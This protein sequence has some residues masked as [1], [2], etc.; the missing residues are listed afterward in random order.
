MIHFVITVNALL[1]FVC[2]RY[3][4]GFV[5]VNLD[6]NISFHLNLKWIE[7]LNGRFIYWRVCC[8]VCTREP[9]RRPR[10]PEFQRSISHRHSNRASMRRSVRVSQRTAD[11]G[12]DTIYEPKMSHAYSDTDLRYEQLLSQPKNPLNH[13]F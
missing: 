9:K 1:P 2:R 8:F 7:F 5:Q 11:S 6:S 4:G 3:N 13:E 12:V 10:R